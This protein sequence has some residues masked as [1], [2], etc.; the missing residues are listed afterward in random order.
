VLCPDGIAVSNSEV[1]ERLDHRSPPR[2]GDW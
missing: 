1:L 2:V